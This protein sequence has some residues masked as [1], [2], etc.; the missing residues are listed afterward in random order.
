MT[1]EEQSS[2][3]GERP[4]EDRASQSGQSFT[5]PWWTLPAAKYHSV[6]VRGRNLDIDV[7]WKIKKDIFVIAWSTF[8]PTR[9]QGARRDL[10]Q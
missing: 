1:E 6:C 7:N 4:K 3:D 10:D 8:L 9:Y 5:Q 2:R